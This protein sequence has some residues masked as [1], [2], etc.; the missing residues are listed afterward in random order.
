MSNILINY[1]L[2]KEIKMLFIKNL[3]PYP[4]S[5]DKIRKI[6]SKYK[7]HLDKIIINRIKSSKSNQ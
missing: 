2:L 1:K 4:H 5:K 7:I 3:D 6:H